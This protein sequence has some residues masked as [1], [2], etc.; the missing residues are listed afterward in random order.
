M[1]TIWIQKIIL[2]ICRMYK[3]QLSIWCLILL[4]L[5][6]K[7]LAS[8]DSSSSSSSSS[9]S[10]CWFL[11]F[12][13]PECHQVGVQ[14]QFGGPPLPPHPKPPPPK[15][16]PPEGI[17]IM[18]QLWLC[19]WCLLSVLDCR[20][21][22]SKY[23]LICDCMFDWCFLSVSKKLRLSCEQVNSWN[24]NTCMC[25]QWMNHW[26]KMY[27]SSLCALLQGHVLTRHVET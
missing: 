23:F 24:I 10:C 1:Q 17:S 26:S 21:M 13:F 18:V 19:D 25:H 5:S 8:E 22:C 2:K 9:S 27:V 3:M 6:F 4:W 16:P 12:F 11:F 15:P 7:F 20:L 14:F